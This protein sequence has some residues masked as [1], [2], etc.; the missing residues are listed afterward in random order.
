MV[1]QR[2]GVLGFMSVYG[3]LLRGFIENVGALCAPVEFYAAAHS[4]G[5]TLFAPTAHIRSDVGGGVPD[6]PAITRALRAD[7][8]SAPTPTKRF[9][10]GG[11]KT[12]GHRGWLPLRGAPPL[13]GEGWP[14][15]HEPPPSHPSVTYGDSSPQGE[16]L[17]TV[18]ASIARP[19]ESHVTAKLHGRIWNPPLRLGAGTALWVP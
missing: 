16:P 10:P 18:G 3:D 19:Q 4:H 5:R 14:Q 1:G 7:M 17:V 11:V 2:A 8:E 13:G 9:G 15:G 6:A 12:C